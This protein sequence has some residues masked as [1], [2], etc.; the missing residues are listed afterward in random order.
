MPTTVSIRMAATEPGPSAWT[1]RSRWWSARS[2]SSV[3]VVAQNSDRYRKG[4]KTC[5]WPRAYSLG[6]RRQSPVATIAAPVLPW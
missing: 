3:S 5:T 2:H 1:T 4:P 6:T